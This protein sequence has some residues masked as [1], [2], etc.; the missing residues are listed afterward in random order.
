MNKYFTAL[1]QAISAFCG[2][3]LGINFD[4]WSLF[5]G[6]YSLNHS[7]KKLAKKVA[8]DFLLKPL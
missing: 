7:L 1:V 6:I 5:Y 8:S 3:L 2:S 4:I